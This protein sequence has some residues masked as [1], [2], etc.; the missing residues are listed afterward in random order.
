[1]VSSPIEP[2][3][4][5]P[6]ELRAAA[7]QLDGHASEFLASHEMTH[8]RA[9][10]VSLGSGLSAAA[11]PQMLTALEVESACLAGLFA[12]NAAGYRDAAAQYSKTDAA[13][14]DQI[15]DASPTP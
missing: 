4:V 5:D 8:S 10:Q 2:L 15:G 12:T 1:M 11:L 13:G 9:S 3:K 6:T 14:G 7:D